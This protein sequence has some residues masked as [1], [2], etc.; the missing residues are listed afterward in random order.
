MTE[1]QKAGERAG[2]GGIVPPVEHRFQKGVAANPG[3]VPKGKRISTYM[4]E[5]GEMDPA[6][7][8]DEKDASKK[9]SAN[10]RIALARLRRAAREEGIR[11]AELILDRTEGAVAPQEPA[12]P[13]ISQIAAAIAA[14]KAAG[15]ELK[16]EDP[17][18]A[19]KP[20]IEAEKVNESEE[21][22]DED[23]A[24]GFSRGRA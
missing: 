20:V 8:P 14:L 4:A 9:L 2:K 3:G 5:Y 10:A 6:D 17:V 12:L 21:N 11:D 16:R 1:R 23:G 7:W 24:E 19:A 22:E 13:M 15:V 18:E